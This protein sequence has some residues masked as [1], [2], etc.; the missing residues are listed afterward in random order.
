[1]LKF[2]LLLAALLAIPALQAQPAFKQLPD[3]PATSTPIDVESLDFRIKRTAAPAPSNTLS[4]LRP[5]LNPARLRPVSLPGVAGVKVGTDPDNGQVYVLRGRPT[6]LP[7]ARPDKEDAYAYLMAMADD[8]GLVDPM[9]ELRITEEIIDEDGHKHLRLKQVYQGLAVHPADARLHAMHADG[10][11]LYTGRLQPTPRDVEV[12]PTLGLQAARTQVQSMFAEQWRDLN[13]KQLAWISGPQLELE[14]VVYSPTGQAPRLAW[15]ANVR[16]NLMEHTSLYLDAHSAEVLETMTHTCGFMGA[17]EDDFPAGLK[18]VGTANGLK[19]EGT[20]IGL[21]PDATVVM[22]G[23]ATVVVQDLY[24]R[25]ITLN[26]FSLQDTFYLL[27]GTRPMF[28]TAGGQLNGFLLTYDGGG[29]SPMLNNFNPGL[30]FSLNNQGW[31]KTEAS[32]HSNAGVAY[33][34]FLDQ[35]GRNSIDGNGGSVYSFMNINETDGTQMDNAFWNGRALFYGN[36]VTAFRRL[37]RGLDVAGHEM[38]HGVIQSTADLIYQE[39]PGAMNESFADIFGYL[40]EGE[41]GDYRL[42]EDVVTTAFP[43]GAL[44]DLRNPNNGATRFGQRGWQPKHMD[45]YVTLPNTEEGD[46]GGVHINSGIPNRAFYLFS[47]DPAVGDVTAGRVYYKA[48]NEFL[49]R[50]S[51]FADLRIAVIEAAQSFGAPVVAAAENAFAGVG[52]GGP[53]GDYTVDLEDNTGDRFLLMTDTEQSALYLADEDGNIT[54]NPLVTVGIGSRPSVTDDGSAAVFVDDQGRLRVYYFGTRELD[55]IE[56]NPGT[57]WRNIAI[58]KDGERIAVTTTDRNNTILIFDFVSGRGRNL[59]LSNP[60]TAGGISTGDVLYADALEW[61]PSGEFLL[62]DALSSLDDGLNFW[63]IGI[64]RAWDIDAAD[65]GDGNIFKLSNS[66][67]EGISIGNPTFSKNSPYIIAYE[68]VDFA[69]D[70]YTIIGT[71]VETG[72]SSRVFANRVINYP[73]YGISDDRIVFD[74]ENQAGD[75][76]LAVVP[77]AADKISR[78]GNPVG[79]ITGG[80]WGYYFANGERS[81]DTGLESPVVEDQQVRVY[82]SLTNDHVT[83]QTPEAELQGPIQVFDLAGRQVAAFSNQAGTQEI[84]LGNLARGTYFV[85]VPAARG[86]VVR[87]VVRQ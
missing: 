81:L 11:D 52:I 47:S 32:V 16:P 21:K 55:F 3:Q 79:L 86:T 24:D 9:Q 68:E 74:A 49:T 5:R 30:R 82:P 8:L 43:S 64:V 31:T 80:H 27:D 67:P 61:E 39:Q 51:R 7:A 10:F 41:T 50:S 60:T 36:G 37:P 26:T 33:Q 38:A 15:Y 48:L 83:V 18:P 56:N 77:M 76:I 58:S 42:G 4:H 29:G 1:M 13:A 45:E 20:A 71:N 25:S 62:Y 28:S 14:L 40:I 78:G 87:R 65:F 17:H 44:R 34:Y 84:S 66:L 35:H 59:T 22:D 6:D 2:N 54:E 63:D 57:N 69:N 53:A 73:N 12:Q 72:A 19:P 75:G 85:A 23:P 46:L 70:T